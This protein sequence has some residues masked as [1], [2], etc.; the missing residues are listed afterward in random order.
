MAEFKISV[1]LGDVARFGGIIDA[2]ILPEL[3]KAVFVVAKQVHTDWIAAV[4]RAKLWSGE[5]VSYEASIKMEPTGPFSALV[6]SDYKYAEEIEN[7]RPPRDLKRMLN[8]SLKV[9]QTKT[10]KRYLIIP[11]RHN[12]PGSDALAAAMPKDVYALARQLAPSSVVGRGTRVSGTG[13][14]DIKT[15]KQITVPTRKYVWGGSLPSSSERK[16]PTRGGDRYAGMYRFDTSSGGKRDSKY[17]TFRVMAE[18][19]P[20]WIVPAQPGQ[21]LA[22]KVADEIQPVAVKYF[23]EAMKRTFG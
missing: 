4:R 11:F 9:R 10:G 2:A 6:W 1:D 8:T 5:K 17:F 23:G 14:F 16:L 20:G 13:A 7:G 19:S 22:K 15:Q 3:N 21:Y 12:T 18:G